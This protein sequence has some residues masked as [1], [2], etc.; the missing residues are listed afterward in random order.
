MKEFEFT[1]TIFK[2]QIFTQVAEKRNK[3]PH[4]ALNNEN[5]RQ[6]KAFV[7]IE[8]HTEI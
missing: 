6:K 3:L 7:C 8:S 2:A 5:Q 4:F 1:I